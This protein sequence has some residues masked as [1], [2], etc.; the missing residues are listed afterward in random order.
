MLMS[1]LCR[2]CVQII[3]SLSICFKKLHLINVGAFA[4]YSVK[5]R[6]I[7]DVQFERRKVNK[8]KPTW[9]L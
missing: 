9:K 2:L 8:S 7:F 4:W 5:I 1:A 3:M 6:V